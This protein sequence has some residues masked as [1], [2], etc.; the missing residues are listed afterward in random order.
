MAAKTHKT[1]RRHR[2]D[3]SGFSITVPDRNGRPLSASAYRELAEEFR[4]WRK[5]KG[6]LDCR[7][8]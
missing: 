3:L 5:R 8:V 6:R 1:K 2:A 7:K 4:N